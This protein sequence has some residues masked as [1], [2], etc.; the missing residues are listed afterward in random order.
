LLLYLSLD[1]FEMTLKDI[2]PLIEEKSNCRVEILKRGGIPANDQEERMILISQCLRKDQGNV[3]ILDVKVLL[4]ASSNTNQPASQPYSPRPST[5]QSPSQPY[6]PRL[7]TSQSPPQPSK[8]IKIILFNSNNQNEILGAVT[9]F[10]TDESLYS[11]RCKI[12]QEQVIS[13]E[14]FFVWNSTTIEKGIE[15][16]KIIEVCLTK[17]NGRE[18][19]VIIKG[20]PGPVPKLLIMVAGNP[21]PIGFLKNV[22]RTISLEQLRKNIIDMIDDYPSSFQFLD[23]DESDS[24]P[25]SIK[26]E[27]HYLLEV[28]LFEGK[29]IR[30]KIK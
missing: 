5:S 19:I 24:I 27:E 6:S 22:P 23:N 29:Y 28:C 12:D 13:G 26:Q 7:S 17:I 3:S 1:S 30:L 15:S 18:G 16:D 8:P 20:G 2:R 10:S 21:D 14:Y 4:S 11:L 25:V 9:L